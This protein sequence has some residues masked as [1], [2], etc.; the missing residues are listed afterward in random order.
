M[1]LPNVDVWPSI[2]SQPI[3]KRR[4]VPWSYLM[5]VCAHSCSLV[6]YSWADW[7]RFIDWM[8]LSGI[9]LMLALTGQEEIQ[10]QVFRKLGLS[11]G[12]IRSWFNG[13]AFLTWSRGQNEYGNSICGPL[14]LS[15][16]KD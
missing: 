12:D 16:M 13:P 15:W 14:P 9:N 7:E 11:D 1:T 3:R 2:G 5:N 10:Y 8:S 6:W 4:V